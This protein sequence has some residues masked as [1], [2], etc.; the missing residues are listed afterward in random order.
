[1][2]EVNEA[3]P[4]VTLVMDQSPVAV[5]LIDEAGQLRFANQAMRDLLGFAPSQLQGMSIFDIAAHRRADMWADSLASLKQ[6]GFR[7]FSSD[8]RSSAGLDVA[9]DLTAVYLSQDQAHYALV[10]ALPS[11]PM[12]VAAP[13]APSRHLDQ[14][15][16]LPTLRV[17]QERLH[18]EAKLAR[19]ES[20]CIALISVGVHHLFKVSGTP[21]MRLDAPLLMGL[22]SRMA[23][24]LRG[25]DTFAHAGNGEF[26]FLLTHRSLDERS[27]LEFS[28]NILES[29]SEPMALA[30]GHVQVSCGIGVVMFPRDTDVSEHM[31][32]Q[33]QCAMRMAQSGQGNQ[34]CFHTPQANATVSAYLTREAALQEALERQEFH[35]LYQPQVDLATGQIA[36]VEALIRWHNPLLGEVEP[37]EF[38]PLAEETGLI[39]PIGTWALKTA[40]AEAARWQQSGVPMV[41]VAVNL[42]S[43]QLNQPDITN[44]IESVLMETG[45]DPHGL[46]IEVTERMLMDNLEHISCVLRD[47]KSIGIEIALDKFGTGYSSLS[48]IR[49]LPIDVIKIDRSL[50]P[51]ITAETQD[52]SIT[53]AIITMAHSLKMKVLAMGV[54]N[55]GELA[56]LIANGC[57]RMQ[58]IHFSPPVTAT[59]IQ[60]L[61]QR[62]QHLSD[63][64]LQR[65]GRSR[66]LL[67]VD[68][69]ENIVS[70]LK[71]L[72]RRDGYHIVTASSG[73]D[74]LQRLAEYDVDVILSD[75]RMPGMTGVEFLRRAKELYPLTVRMVL[76]GYT[77]LQSITD[78]INEGAIYKFLTK[79]WD[80]ERVRAHIQEAFRQKEL[81]D[82]NRQLDLQV[83][84]ANSELA[85]V[86]GK[87]NRLLESQR[88]RI[89]REETS[90]VSA[91]GVL[92]NIPAP[93]IG[94]DQEGL[95]VFMNIDAE[96][97]FDNHA[98]PLGMHV[99]EAE[100]PDLARLWRD[101]DGRHHDV[102]IHGR[103]LR[104]VC[105]PMSGNAHSQG[106]LMVLMPENLRVPQGLDHD[107]QTS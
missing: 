10:Y 5:V 43:R 97:L 22:T 87:L 89:L 9:V 107:N 49:H 60:T 104:A 54:E 71:R 55:E 50:V 38:L 57:D 61:L 56:L 7:K 35:V 40:C 12:P 15:T 39:L 47:L 69:E 45:L 105:R 106:S 41:R 30:D 31:L 59:G 11:N 77:E 32:R 101:K 90:L 21:A 36:G 73:T 37:D 25:T 62:K 3:L 100:S 51:D 95:V 81:A 18:A 24:G 64:V 68:D 52:V 17:L 48:T 94:L 27:A 82:E 70:S 72:L 65:K 26:L 96:A 53:R 4:M 1:M 19:Q 93:L 34:I 85:Q 44:T 29:L 84:E 66:T 58:G 75:Q 76:S 86:N 42:S 83:Q 2:S 103:H 79:P 99:E 16:G 8:W 6:T 78:A 33:A 88:Q 91:R 102:Q 13:A 14:A 92:E 67:I 80:D 28:R 98:C 23:P 20:R 46:T 74:G 63:E